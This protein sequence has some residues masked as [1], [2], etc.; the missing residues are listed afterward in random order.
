[1][2]QFAA[3]LTM[4]FTERALPRPLRAAAKAG[5]KAVEFL[6]PYAYPAAEIQARLEGQRP[7]AGAAQPAGRRLGRRRARHR[8][9]PRPRGR[10][11]RRRGARPSSTPR[12][13]ACRSS[14]AWPARRRPASTTPTLRQTFVDN[15]RF[16]AA[17][18]KKAG[19]EAADRA[20]QHLRHSRLLPQPHR[21]GAVDPGRGGRRQRL[22]AVRHLPRAAHG[23]RAGR[24]DEQAPA[25]ASATSSWPTTR[26]ATSRAPARSTMPSCSRTSTASATP[27]GSAANTSPPPPPKPAW[28]GSQRAGALNATETNDMTTSTARLGFIGLGIMGAPMAGHLLAAGHRCSS[29]T[30]SKV[31][32]A[33]RRQPA[34]PPAP[35]PREVAERADIIFTM[36]P[37]TP[38]VEAVLFGEDGVAAGLS[39]GQDRGR[40]ELDLADR[41][42]GLRAEDQRAGLR[43]PGRAGVRR[44]GRRQGRQR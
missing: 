40:H 19:P 10:I 28:A 13:W 25:R 16:A 32:A 41:D 29:H 1:M 17:E 42:Q 39:Q 38:D 18:L 11:P 35:A 21:A 5:F 36:V 33:T 24:H 43:L 31:P 30:R 15:L 9:P 4:L 12:R 3:N 37:D 8:L 44:R 2:P 14:T 7:E 34:P 23:R 22:R 26:A 27:A 20:D 6:F